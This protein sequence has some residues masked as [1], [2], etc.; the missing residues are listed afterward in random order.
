MYMPLVMDVSSKKGSVSK[1]EL[2][3]SYN[4]IIH[5]IIEDAPPS[6]EKATGITNNNNQPVSGT[7]RMS[8]QRKYFKNCISL[9]AL[10]VAARGSPSS[11]G[12][13][14]RKCLCWNFFSKIAECSVGHL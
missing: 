11:F 5:L 3:P 14:N 7:L 1:T 6:Y 10:Y 2:L 8:Y 13:F 12:K 9:T 4:E